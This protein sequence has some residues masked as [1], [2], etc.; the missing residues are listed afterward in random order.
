[1]R[2]LKRYRSARTLAAGHAFVQNLRRGYYDI[3]TDVPQ[4]L[5]LRVAFDELTLCHLTQP[6]PAPNHSNTAEPSLNATAPSV[7]PKEG[8]RAFGTAGCSCRRRVA[9]L[10]WRA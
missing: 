2:G 9:S 7:P 5:R 3:A 6:L 10:I 8:L 4:R 1:M